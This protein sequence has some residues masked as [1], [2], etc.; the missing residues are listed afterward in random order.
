MKVMIQEEL[1]AFLDCTDD[2]C[3]TEYKEYLEEL[4]T[5]FSIYHKFNHLDSGY[6]LVIYS[7][8]ITLS[9][10]DANTFFHDVLQYFKYHLEYASLGGNGLR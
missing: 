3:S 2:S 10:W 8:K 9:E 7:Q 5:K 4:L 6:E 1:H